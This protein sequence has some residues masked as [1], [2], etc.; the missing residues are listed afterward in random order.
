MLRQYELKT[1]EVRMSETSATA[2]TLT[3][4]AASSSN[5]IHISTK[6]L[7]IILQINSDCNVKIAPL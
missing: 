1:E 2:Q 5:S 4:P 7:S 3:Y 6:L